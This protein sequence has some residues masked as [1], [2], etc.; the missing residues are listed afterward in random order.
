M[1]ERQWS[2]TY[3]KQISRSVLGQVKT[4]KPQR[5]HNVEVNSVFVLRPLLIQ[6]R[7]VEG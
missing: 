4:S 2:L 5:K 1:G 7:R 3:S 6:L